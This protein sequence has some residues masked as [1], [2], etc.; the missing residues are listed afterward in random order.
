MLV[1]GD[2]QKV[3]PVSRFHHDSSDLST[4]DVEG[5]GTVLVGA[6]DAGALVFV[7]IRCVAEHT[8]LE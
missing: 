1:A 5:G 7:G 3:G 4:C 8:F 6:L 2:R